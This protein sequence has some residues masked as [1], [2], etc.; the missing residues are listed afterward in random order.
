MRDA[1]DK[2][3]G[4]VCIGGRVITNLRYA[5][6]TTLIAG[7]KEE[8][9]EIMERVRKTS[10]K[11]G[12]YLNVLKTKVMTTGDIGEVSV[13]GKTV[14][15]VTNFV[16][17]GALISK[18]GRCDKEIRRRIAMGKAAMG[19]LT[20]VWKDRGITLQTKVKLVKALVFPIVLHGAETWTMRKTERK[21]IDAFELWCWRRVMRVSWMERKTNVW[22]LE[23][24]KPKWTL[25][26]RVIKAALSYFGHV[27]RKER[28]M[29][30]DVMLG[31]M[32]RKR[33]RGRPRTKW[34]DTIKDVKGPSINIMRRDA[35]ERVEWRGATAAV[36]RGRTRLDGTR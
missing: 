10:E 3:E 23:N 16:F 22:V 36:A 25:E 4:G 9:T 33:R 2:W 14:E 6:D 31:G 21:K 27:V 30:N 28:G 34:L 12:L 35:R 24:V 5:D 1:L 7:T 8:L 26:S 32:R 15:V 20:T 11:A 29:E 18:D 17:L 19:G 13:D